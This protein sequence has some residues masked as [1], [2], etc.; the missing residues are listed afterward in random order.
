MS[1]VI[2]IDLGTRFSCVSIWKN[3]RLEIIP[4]SFGNRTVPSI[5]SFY[6]SA[7]LMGHNALALKDINPCNTIFD[8]KRI[9]GR[10]TDDPALNQIKKLVSYDIIEDDGNVVIQLDHSDHSLTHKKTYKPEEI[11]AYILM[12]IKKMA[13]TYLGYPAEKAVITVPAYFNDSQRQ[14]TMDSAI[15]AGLDVIKIINEPTAAALAYG[16]GDRKG[17]V[18]I[19]DF[20]AGTLDISL[21]NINCG[22]FRILAVGGNTHLG[23]EDIDYLL[24]NHCINEFKAK[25]NIKKIM[26][27][28]LSQLKLKNAVENAKKIL[29]TNDKAVVC[30]DNFFDGNRLYTTL[31]RDQLDLICNDLFIM[32]I[33]PIND[34][35]ESCKMS[36]TEIDDVVL[37]GGS[38]RV[39]KIQSLI[40]DY[41]KGT[42]IK[43][44]NTNLNP[45]EVVS[46]GASIYGYIMT[47]QND[48]FSENIVLLDIT[49]LSLGVETLQK[50]M[51]VIIPRNTV[52]PTKKTKIF[53]TDTDDQDSVSIKIFE[54]ERKLTKHNFHLGTFD[55]MGFEKGP[56]GYPLISITFC[57]DIHGILRITAV[58]KKSMVENT[59]MITSTWGA[60][61][62]LAKEEIDSIIENAKENEQIDSTYSHRIILIH[63][64]KSMCNAIK[65]NLKDDAFNLTAIDKK[66]IR[67]DVKRTIKWIDDTDLSD[68]EIKKL[69]D[70]TKWIEKTYAPLIIQSSKNETVKA[71]NNKSSGTLI[72]G[73][74][75]DEVHD[76]VTFYND[77]SD[78]DR[79]EIKMIKQTIK[80]LGNNI[81]SVI[82]NPVSNFSE[83]DIVMVSDYIDSVN[84]WL[85]T[86]TASSTIEFIAK[87]SEINKFTEEIMNKYEG[88]TMFKK[89]EKF[90]T[91]DELHMLC[92]TL[93]TSLNSQFFSLKHDETEKLSKHI[94]E[95]LQWLDSTTEKNDCEYQQ[96][97]SEIN[98]ICNTIYQS[99]NRIKEIEH[100]Q[101]DS[102]SDDDQCEET[103][104]IKITEN[105]SKIIDDMDNN[106]LLKVDI[107]K[108]HHNNIKYKN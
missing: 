55:L 57:V 71:L 5:V 69:E 105:L 10:R 29:S 47:H 34:V 79:E 56:R 99:M 48:P 95:T 82:N 67:T 40:L 104:G 91:R 50:Q 8:I 81:I 89:N 38:T 85:Y 100:I 96:K 77:P 60:K 36:R 72:H 35:L 87:I 108:L 103:N 19:Y 58:E 106:V 24:M 102:D 65:I 3:Q 9:I 93:S 62:R 59:I 98:D 37:V 7:K 20:G 16:M 51:S 2:G 22:V 70:K 43:S 94:L 45:D 12:E 25:N 92:M 33:K 88:Q 27:S 76:K 46:A 21:M 26:I 32:C 31:T 107:N 6:K 86:T 90:S 74:E 4:D 28:K 23:G 80:E 61:G 39:P 84:I 17:N 14:A 42:K 101:E 1:C 75:E 52:I 73:E 54:G 63:K 41:F 66:K 68:I 53:T 49:P 78:Y 11:C 13:T 64:I 15:I 83:E 44:L 97:I 18:L 30:V